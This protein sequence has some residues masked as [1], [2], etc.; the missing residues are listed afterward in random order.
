MNNDTNDECVGC[1]LLLSVNNGMPVPIA[2]GFGSVPFNFVEAAGA[3]S[4]ATL[5]FTFDALPGECNSSC[6]P[7]RPCKIRNPFVSLAGI[8]GTLTVT[9]TQGTVSPPAQVFV[10]HAG[11]QLIEP[12]NGVGGVGARTDANP[13]DIQLLCGGT[14][15]TWRFRY[16]CL[17]PSLGFLNA[18]E[19]TVTV[20]C[21]A[22]H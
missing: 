3:N 8:G 13:Y 12:V 2:G 15:M 14:S 10:L 20:V 6:I 5:M 1:D 9:C 7:K 16:E 11:Q 22:C 18:Q 4:L 19:L 21:T 17:D